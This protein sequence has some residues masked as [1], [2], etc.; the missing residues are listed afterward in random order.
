[1]RFSH[2]FT[3]EAIQLNLSAREWR[4]VVGE[5]CGSLCAC[6]R[7][8]DVR[9]AIQD[10][11]SREA[12]GST[13]VGH[14]IAM[15]HAVTPAVSQPLIAYGRSEQGIDF[16][17][18]DGELAKHIFLLLSPPQRQPLHLRILARLAR[19]GSNEEFREHLNTVRTAGEVLDGIQHYIGEHDEFD[20]PEGMPKVLVIGEDKEAFALAAHI[21]LL[22]SRVNFWSQY[23][24]R[25][26]VPK[27]MKGI[28]AEGAVRGFARFARVGGKLQEALEGMDLIMVVQSANRHRETA[29]ILAPHLREGQAV[30]LHP[31]RLGG[32]LEFSAELN[33]AKCSAPV[34][35]AEARALPHCSSMSSPA[36]VTIQ[37]KPE[38]I[39][40]AALPAYHLPDLLPLL[41]AALPYYS[42]GDHSLRL[43]LE[44][45]ST[46]LE[47]AL[48][49]L[50]AS[51]I[52]QEGSAFRLYADGVTPG[53][54][55]ILEIMDRERLAVA[56][57]LGF[58]LTPLIQWLRLNQGG[59]GN[60]LHQIIESIT[61]FQKI[62]APESLDGSLLSDSVPCG[63]TPLV[64]IGEHLGLELPVT[65]SL[66]HLAS[67]LL[68]HD[69]FAEGRTVETMGLSELKLKDIH[70]ILSCGA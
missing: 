31:G 15:P 39:P 55:R 1:M 34:Y 65:R 5:M 40:I 17:A 69:F 37:L 54:C 62:K 53:V 22:G 70:R 28:T 43:G 45:V 29:R 4:G 63:L 59:T 12:L 56:T 51:P 35:L 9:Q 60:K 49:L 36:Q 2:L 52:E 25:L 64:S 66:V 7:V 50:N 27:A 57:A 44:D 14:G 67:A 11:E 26:E 38:K 13:S 16:N 32:T 23:R 68:G 3:F 61:R 19:L 10:V 6:G 58:S 18:P 20:D 48:I 24:D 47:T 21:A 41:S 46:F 33:R 30:V 8:Q 42:A